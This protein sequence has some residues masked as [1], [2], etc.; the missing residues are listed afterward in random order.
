MTKTTATPSV[1]KT[2]LV[3]ST[4]AYCGVGC[5]VD[6]ECQD[7]Q[8]V[9]LSGT[10]DHPANFGR[11]CVKGSNLLQTTCNTNRLAAPEVNGETVDWLQAIAHVADNFK[12]I[13]AEH[14]KE[15]VAFYVSGQ[16]L[17]EDYYVANKLMKGYI[18]SANIDTNSRLCMSSAVAAYKRAF[19]EDVVPCSY[20]DV[21]QT[22]ALILIGSNAAWTH[23]VVFQRIERARQINP[24]FKLVVIDPRNTATAQTADLF[25]A[26]KPGSDAALYQGLLAYLAEQQALDA[27]YIEQHTENFEPCLAQA[28][29]WTLAKV[30]Q[31]CGL[32]QAELEQF[33]Q[34][35]T[36]SSKVV[37]MYSMGINQSS[38][39][40]D[41]CQSIINAHLATGKMGKS[42]CGPFSITGQPNAM[43][44][45]EVGGLA[46]Q[47]TA[48]MELDNPAHRALVQNFWQSP[49]I[50]ARAG[51]K[52]VDLFD[53][54]LD[55]EIKAVWIIATNPAVS[56]PNSQKVKQALSACDLV[57]VSDCVAN[58]DTLAFA[59]VKL[60]ATTWLEKNGTVTNSERRISRQ[61]SVVE[62]FA[63]AKHDWQIISLVAQAM[64]FDGF[65]YQHP[66]QI[67]TEYAA[68]SGFEN[69]GKTKRIFDISALS[70]LTIAQ[71][72]ALAPVQWPVSTQYPEGCAQVF[73]QQNFATKTGKAQFVEITPQLPQQHHNQDYPYILNSGRMRD[74][75][76]TM[77]R[78]G[79]AAVLSQHSAKPYVMINPKDVRHLK[80]Q[81]HDLVQLSSTLG[82]I[83]VPVQ[84]TDQVGQGQCF[85]PIH[86]N[87]QFASN[88]VVSTL[89]DSKVDALSGQPE[90]KFVG[91]NIT[92]ISCQHHVELYLAQS[93][94][95]NTDMLKTMRYWLKS[96][97]NHSHYWQLASDLPLSELSQTI[98]KTLALT[99][100]WL[101]LTSAEHSQLVCLTKGK[102]QCVINLQQKPFAQAQTWVDELFEQT[103]L[104]FEQ[105]QALLNNKTPEHM[106]LGRKICSC[107]NVHEQQIIEAITAGEHSVAALGDSLKCGTNCG[108]CKPELQTLVN[109]H[110]SAQIIETRQLA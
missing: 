39:G 100:E 75:W 95:L 91:V 49:T 34:L 89:Y 93:M 99:G 24:E 41:K 42:G 46:N 109:N 110:S 78:T 31:F 51:A 38:S 29:Y 22:D 17:T 94:Q 40:V 84:V 63:E 80:L 59:D 6:I 48:H 14:G 2:H 53:K 27:E 57:V 87:A 37:T 7:N 65:N 73:S 50:A 16:C 106:A 30:S 62:P 3:Q 71:Y 28:A 104:N 36:Q 1:K 77:T 92:P 98:Q 70:S 52:A 5:G 58:N 107:F 67:F 15:A 21:E 90:T 55:G 108:S 11:L 72:D 33:Y 79:K 68:L 105:V 12:R 60:P 97:L 66:Q 69:T 43:G 85:M 81:D 44:G 61:R 32:S 20:Q 13:I 82:A 76:H 8:P 10:L 103:S 56:L 4:C 101:Q 26:I 18:G 74:Q 96:V 35:F 54:I 102:V 86:W 83:D 45:R 19:G 88:A 47:L 23:P 25:L 9:K 64:G